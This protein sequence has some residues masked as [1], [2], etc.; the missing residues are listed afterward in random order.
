MKPTLGWIAIQPLVGLLSNP[1]SDYYPTFGRVIIQPLVGSDLCNLSKRTETQKVQF[2]ALVLRAGD[3]DLLSSSDRVWGKS[4]FRSI[5]GS[6]SAT[7]RSNFRCDPNCWASS[8][9]RAHYRRICDQGGVC[10]RIVL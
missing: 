5:P 3:F 2:Q 8:P 10:Y 4:G 1:W 9:E 6:L 7:S